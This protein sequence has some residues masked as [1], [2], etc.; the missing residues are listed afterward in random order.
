MFYYTPNIGMLG[1]NWL[2]SWT[3]DFFF[4]CYLLFGLGFVFVLFFCFL[5]FSFFNLNSFHLVIID[6]RSSVI[7]FSA[8]FHSF[9]IV[10]IAIVTHLKLSLSTS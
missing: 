10:Q 3:L 6:R 5:F 4:R 8:L 2:G 7:Y 1:G 9:F